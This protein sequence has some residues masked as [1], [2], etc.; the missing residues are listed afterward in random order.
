LLIDNQRSFLLEQMGTNT[1]TFNQ[2]LCSTN[3]D[4]SI[5]S[6]P[7]RVREPYVRGD[8]RIKRVTRNERHQ[9]NK[10]PNTTELPHI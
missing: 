9:G 2:I 5:K 6:V 8:G 1:D 4:I 3:W 7:S 10:A